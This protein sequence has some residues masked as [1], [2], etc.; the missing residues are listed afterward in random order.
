[1]DLNRN[2]HQLQ[3]QIDQ[4]CQASQRR[5]QDVHLVAVTKQVTITQIQQLYALGQRDFAENRPQVFL[6]KY[7]ALKATCP[8]IRWHFIGNVQTRPNACQK[9]P[10]V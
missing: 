3:A 5:R 10:I 4:C 8:D 2:Y 9:K 7:H 6:D 1:M